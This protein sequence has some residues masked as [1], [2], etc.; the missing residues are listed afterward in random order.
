MPTSHQTQSD[1]FPHADLLLFWLVFLY[2]KRILYDILLIV[3][4][5][6]TIKEKDLSYEYVIEFS[7]IPMIFIS[8]PGIR[9]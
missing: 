5:T 8:R 7:A 9:K 3:R 1:Q 6:A 2:E 4:K